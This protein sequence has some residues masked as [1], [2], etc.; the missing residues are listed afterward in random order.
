[1][2]PPVTSRGQ[3]FLHGDRVLITLDQLAYF[4]NIR[5]LPQQKDDF[6]GLIRVEFDAHLDCCTRIQTGA[7][8]IGERLALEG[9]GSRHGPI[10]SQKFGSVRCK[11]GGRRG[12]RDKRDPS[13]EVRMISIA[14]QQGTA[15]GIPAG[16]DV[17]LCFLTV[18][19]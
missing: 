17:E 1:M 13:I 9:R 5:A 7:G 6:G 15:L 16:N 14:C 4:L 18:R 3:R 11:A 12:S 19:T 10:T 8:S 2:I